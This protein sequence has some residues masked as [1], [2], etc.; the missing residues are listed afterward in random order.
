[1]EQNDSSPYVSIVIPTFNR[2]RLLRRAI[3][4]VLNQ[5]YSNFEIIVVDDCS[6]DNTEDAVRSIRDERI[7]YIR[8][9]KNKGAFEARNTGIKAAKGKY[10]AF[11]DSDDVWLP[12]KLD[13]QMKVFDSASRDIGVV[14]TSFWLIHNSSRTMHPPSDIRQTEGNIHEALLE[15]NFVGTPT[16]VVRKECF[17]EAGLFENLPRLQE[18]SLWLKISKR[19][20]FKHINEPLVNAYQQPDSISRNTDAYVLARKR[21]LEK[22]F[23]EISKKPK[24]L[25]RHY[26]EIGTLQCLD[27]EVKEGRNCF[28]KAIRISPLDAKLLLST[29]A[30]IISISV[31]SKV[32]AIYLR[33]KSQDRMF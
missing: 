27:G 28:F 5:T 9:E 21:I 10:I 3:Q 24:I 32:V 20:C 26:F 6:S 29:L 4:S 25:K 1:M 7:L 12:E 19:Y 16:A 30:S 23:E 22:Y 8:H 18:W 33:I 2:A 17:E 13:K 11:Q 31:Y 15:A 14:Y